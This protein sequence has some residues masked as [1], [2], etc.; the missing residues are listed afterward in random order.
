[1]VWCP[2]HVELV[3]V[4]RKKLKLLIIGSGGREH[5]LVWKL[6]KSRQVTKIYI[7]PGNGGTA[8]ESKCENVLVQNPLNFAQEQNIDLTIVGP[9]TPLAEGIVDSFQVAGLRIWGP[10]KAAAQIEASKA[11]AKSFMKRHHIPAA[12]SK[13]FSDFYKALNYL[14][15]QSKLPVIKAS[16][17]AA[18][19]GVILPRNL[20][21]AEA[22]LKAI[23]LE[24]KFGTAGEK[25]II[26]ECLEG[27]EASV[28]AFCDGQ[29]IKIMPPAQDHKR[30]LDG[31]KG[32]NT[33]GMGAYAP[34]P[35]I[36]TKLLQEITERII[37]PA[38][39]GL[40]AEG[41]PYVGVLYAGIMLT[42]SGPKALE[43]N[44]RFGDPEAQV[45]L[46]LLQTDL[47]DIIESS[48]SGTLDSLKVHWQQS[49]A[50]TVVLASKGYPEAYEK[51]KA[52][53]GLEVKEAL[54]FHAG[55]SLQNEQVITSGG[56]VLNVVGVADNLK[57]ALKKAYQAIEGI[58]FEGMHYRKD[59]G[60]KGLS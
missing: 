37:Q 42:R 26:E 35:L 16:G 6:A 45:L 43:F 10:S 23:M 51:G 14:K 30:A 28:L 46:P 5:A 53:A 52:I 8:R 57:D 44:C 33:G 56:R 11:F 54:I 29:S 17:L 59:I 39:S 49:S 15:A 22:A 3:E 55:T 36:T 40:K 20:I 50:A 41:T 31:D 27:Q 12:S 38:I 7:A 32:L 4:G 60:A 19:K 1:M 58:Y 48:I 18:G 13:T 47:L 21:E 24:K 34:A 25:V 2:N 9:E